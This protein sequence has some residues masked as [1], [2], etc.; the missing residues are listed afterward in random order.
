MLQKSF[1]TL[2]QAVDYADQRNKNQQLHKFIA[3]HR[4]HATTSNDVEVF[5]IKKREFDKPHQQPS[6]N[7]DRQYSSHSD[8]RPPQRYMPKTPKYVKHFKPRVETRSCYYC[9]K[10]GHLRS[11]CYQR[12]R[13]VN[14]QQSQIFCKRCHKTGHIE[15]FCRSKLPIQ[16]CP[17]KENFH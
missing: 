15:K 5:P 2:T 4:A 3:E 11:G 1:T 17:Q 6:P 14:S 8:H 10:V 13:D 7:A 12:L 9:G 16:Y